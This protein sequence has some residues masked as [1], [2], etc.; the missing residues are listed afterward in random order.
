MK[1][2]KSL[3]LWVDNTPWVESINPILKHYFDGMYLEGN[4]KGNQVITKGTEV[5]KGKFDQNHTIAYGLN[6][7]NEGITIAHPV[8]LHSDFK[9]F[10]KNSNDEAL[11]MFADENDNHGRIIIDTGITKLFEG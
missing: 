10:A 11:I 4:Y 1:A 5:V 3:Y 9:L 8:K 2:K 7:L 6:N